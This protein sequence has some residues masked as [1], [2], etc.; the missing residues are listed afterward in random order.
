MARL[1]LGA[2]PVLQL[3]NPKNHIRKWSKPK[4]ALPFHLH[5]FTIV[6]QLAFCTDFRN[7]M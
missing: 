4:D 1:F 6:N 2:S 3:F 5:C 7:Q